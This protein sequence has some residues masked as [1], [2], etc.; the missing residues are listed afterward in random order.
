MTPAKSAMSLRK[1]EKLQELKAML[2]SV[3]DA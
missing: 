1:T 2:A 3:R